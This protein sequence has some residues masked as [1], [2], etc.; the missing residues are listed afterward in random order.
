MKFHRLETVKELTG[1][2][3]SAIYQYIA[4]GTFPKQVPLGGRAVGWLSDEIDA[5]ILA[6]IAE[7]DSKNTESPS[8]H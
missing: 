1:L 3:R 8:A 5:W 2:G 6:R 7:R 4:E